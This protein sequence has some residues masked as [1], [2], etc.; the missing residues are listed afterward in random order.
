MNRI[1]RKD[2]ERKV[3]RLAEVMHT[4]VAPEYG[5][6]AIGQIRLIHWSPGDGKTRYDI[7]IYRPA[8]GE[9][10]T[11]YGQAIHGYTFYT[12]GAQAF[13]EKLC[14]AI[15]CFESVGRWAVPE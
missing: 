1:T 14:F 10:H 9:P 8:F 5:D 11:P 7:E 4:T 15:A 12:L 13:Y 3:E 6:A 2:I